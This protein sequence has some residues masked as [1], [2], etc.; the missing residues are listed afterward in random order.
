MILDFEVFGA[1]CEMK[2]FKINGV[3]ASYEDFG[4][5]YDRDSLGAEPYCCRDMRFTRKPL[6]QII[7]DKYGITKAEYDEICDK[8]E[9]G[10]SFGNCGW[11]L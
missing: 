9:E 1:L 7:L 8:L 6:R 10:L 4:E 3:R 5:K 11:C 2:T